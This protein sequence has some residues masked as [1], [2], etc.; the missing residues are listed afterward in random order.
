MLFKKL[1]RIISPRHQSKA[2]QAKR[3]AVVAVLVVITIPVLIG[4]AAL[5]I[6]VGYLQLTRQRMQTSADA[7][8][9]AAAW[10]LYDS[11]GNV[12]PNAAR[13]AAQRF[14]AMNSADA[15]HEFSFGRMDDPFD[16]ASPFVVSTPENANAFMVTSYRSAEHGNP[17]DLFFAGIFGKLQ[18]DVSASAVSAYSY[19]NAIPALPIALK[20][21]GFGPI[22]PDIVI[23]NPGKD[24]PSS[25]LN[26]NAF[27]IG[28]QVTVF[29]F[30]KG[31][32]S[33]VHLI[34][35]TNDIPGEAQ[36]GKAM[37]GEIPPAP[38]A[39]GD[40]LPVLGEGT[41]HNGLGLK[42]A[43]RLDDGD[44]TNDIVAMAIVETTNNS[45][46][47]TGKLSGNVR[48]V[49][50]IVIQLIGIIPETILD[51]NDPQGTGKTINIELL[52]GKVVRHAVSGG[53]TGIAPG[54]VN[55]PS[56]MVPQLVR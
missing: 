39:L 22:D 36:I 12:T 18:S 29:T 56:A 54:F 3:S 38:L 47:A 53:G 43:R 46:D 19:A 15:V 42:L 35:N 8:V 27:E 41:G 40:E 50:F 20:T 14:A 13:E 11:Q 1:L 5:A 4:M 21:P 44:P 48:I 32:K 9:M 23:A 34:L 24:G 26:G 25:P 55:G 7:A 37:T 10:T 52:V 51:P 49:D 45:R 28:E 33:P 2:D 6:D 31:K 17:L 30:G 16:P